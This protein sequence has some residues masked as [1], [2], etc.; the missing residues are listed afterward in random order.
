MKLSDNEKS[1]L[2]NKKIGFVFQ[3]HELL[4][5]FTAIENVCLPSWI[6]KKKMDNAREEAIKIFDEF[7]LLKS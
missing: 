2:R 6:S 1:I 7:D 5:E 3:F 4:P